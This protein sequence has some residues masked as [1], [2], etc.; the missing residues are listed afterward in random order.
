MLNTINDRTALSPLIFAAIKHYP[1]PDDEQWKL[2]Q[3]AYYVSNY[4][5]VV[6]IAKPRVMPWRLVTHDRGNH[7]V[8]T[9]NRSTLRVDYAVYSAFR[10]SGQQIGRD[11]KLCHHDGDSTNVALHNLYLVKRTYDV[12][13]NTVDTLERYMQVV[14]KAKQV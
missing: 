13:L 7:Y 5:I 9:V 14:N 6:T 12:D 11:M 8:V 3:G 1:Q 4:G 10:N 2:F